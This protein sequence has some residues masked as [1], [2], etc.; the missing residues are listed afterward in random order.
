MKQESE[1]YKMAQANKT[2]KDAYFNFLDEVLEV[3]ESN[4]ELPQQLSQLLKD[5][6]GETK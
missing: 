3:I 4:P 6:T 1:L 5:H 2:L